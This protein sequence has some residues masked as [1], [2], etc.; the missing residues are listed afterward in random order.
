MQSFVAGS[1]L[2]IEVSFVQDGETVIPDIGSV[3]YTVR[4]NTGGAVAGQTDL[5]VSTTS[6]TTAI[7]VL[8]PQAV[9]VK[10]L[11]FEMRYI[12]TTYLLNGQT[13]YVETTYRLVDRIPLAIDANSVRSL[14]GLQDNELPDSDI[15]LPMA[16]YLVANDVG[17]DVLDAALITGTSIAYSANRA[18]AARALLELL[19]SLQLR[20]NAS[21]KSQTASASRLTN[22]DF[23]KVTAWLGNI[24]SNAQLVLTGG[25]Y[26]PLPLIA[27]A[28]PVD[29]ITG[30]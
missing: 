17:R 4:D 30:A 7:S 23:D 9:N 16:Y 27:A 24:Y 12:T 14:I 11:A 8:V 22:I 19:P 28:L 13:E 26:V 5:S 10:A 20:A 18:I 15:D 2:S 25:L 21:E 3:S 1:P 29:V 6:D